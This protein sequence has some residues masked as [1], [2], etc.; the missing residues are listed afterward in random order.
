MCRRFRVVRPLAMTLMLALASAS[1]SARGAFVQNAAAQFAADS[2]RL[3]DDVT[4]A[5]SAW[6]E[7]R[8]L[9][10]VLLAAS[11]ALEAGLDD[12][13]ATSRSLRALEDRFA[14]AL[15]AAFRQARVTSDSRRRVYDAMDRLAAAGRRV[16]QERRK[17]FDVPIP[18]GLQPWGVAPDSE[19]TA[20]DLG[21]LWTT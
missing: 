1:V 4:A 12:P 9:S 21:S 16:E 8:R 19:G 6:E 3:E 15:E 18:A 7:Q 10:Q 13:D 11:Q 20:P 17:A 5:Q 14:A 2:N